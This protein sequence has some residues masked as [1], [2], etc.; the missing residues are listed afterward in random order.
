MY[1]WTLERGG[2]ITASMQIS[3]PGHS[4]SGRG[5][6]GNSSIPLRYAVRATPRDL[7]YIGLSPQAG[8][9]TF[10]LLGRLTA[11]IGTG[12]GLGMESRD[13]SLSAGQPITAAG[14][15]NTGNTMYLV[16][17]GFGHA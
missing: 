16:E 5:R 8:I 7:V 2:S 1:P 12:L 17:V 3:A 13:S 15:D 4:R 10:V 6:T 11:G 14:L 9:G